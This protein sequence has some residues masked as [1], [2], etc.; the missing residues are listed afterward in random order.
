MLQGE[1]LVLEAFAG[2]ETDHTRIPVGKGVCGTE[3]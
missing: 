1:E 2:R 3:V